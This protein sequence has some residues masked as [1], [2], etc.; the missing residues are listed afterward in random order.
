VYF[1]TRQASGPLPVSLTF[2]NVPAGTAVAQIGGSAFASAV[3]YHLVQA[4]LT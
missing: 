4:D 2:N 1:G 3:G